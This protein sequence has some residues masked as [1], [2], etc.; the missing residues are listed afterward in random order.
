MIVMNYRYTRLGLLYCFSIFGRTES[1]DVG[2]LDVREEP[3]MLGEGASPRPHL[4]RLK[5]IGAMLQ[6]Q[7]TRSISIITHFVN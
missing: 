7:L 2:P 6:F 1:L 4:R 3:K 5:K